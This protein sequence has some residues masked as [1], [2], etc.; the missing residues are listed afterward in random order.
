MVGK[1]GVCVCVR[2][3]GR[4]E[5]AQSTA[6]A[7]RG[8]SWTV[9]VELT[10]CFTRWAPAALSHLVLMSVCEDYLVLISVFEEH[11]VVMCECK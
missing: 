9:I 6:G 3:V 8:D 5:G 1:M 11:F 7:R 10:V 2:L 4:E